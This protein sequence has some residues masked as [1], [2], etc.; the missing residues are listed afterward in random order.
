MQALQSNR[1]AH[2]G[3]WR[4]NPDPEGLFRVWISGQCLGFLYFN[5][6][7]ACY[8]SDEKLR[9][10]FPLGRVTIAGPKTFELYEEFAGNHAT[11]VRPDGQ[12]I[13]STKFAFRERSMEA[14][15]QLITAIEKSV[16][17]GMPDELKTAVDQAKEMAGILP[18]EDTAPGAAAESEAEE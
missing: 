7:S 9:L 16:G 15:V 17:E 1:K 2:D 14:L 10:E 4:F 11:L 6:H 18:V 12:D 13:I 3:G 8:T 5:L